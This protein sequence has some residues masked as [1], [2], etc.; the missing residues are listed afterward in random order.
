MLNKSLSIAVVAMLA[1]CST[2]QPP[3]AP[4][5]VQQ[6]PVVTVPVAPAP[7][8][9]PAAALRVADRTQL[10][11]LEL[12]TMWTFENPPLTYWQQQY[13]FTPTTQWLDHARLSSVRF[14]DFC[15]ASFVSSNGLVITNHH[16]GRECVE[17][18]SQ[19]GTDYV[20][21]GFYAATRAE[22]KVCPGLYLDQLVE[23]QNVTARVQAASQGANAN[24]IAKAQAAAIDSIQKECATQSKMQCQVVTLFHG[25]QYQLYKY[26]RYSPVKLVFAPELQAGFF[27]GDPDNFTYPRYDLDFSV[28]RA[29]DADGKTPAQ[30]PQYLQ[31]STTPPNDGDL[32]FVTGNPGSTSRQIPVSEVLYEREYHHPFVIQFLTIQKDLLEQIA[33][34]GPEAEQQVRQNL[35]E[36]ENSLKAY[37]GQYT[38]LQDTML[39]GQKIRWER[40]L[41][42]RVN[43]DANLRA[44][45]GDVWDR[46]ADIQLAKM[47]V[48]PRLNLANAEWLGA[49]HLL[50]AYDLARY[51][52]YRNTP[53]AQ[54][55]EDLR[56]DNW[57]QIESMMQNAGSPNP[58]ISQALLE[59]HLQMVARWLPA[60][61]SLR[62]HFLMPNET[63]EAAAQRIIQNSH[64]MEAAFRSQLIAGG[65]AALASSQDP[66][67]QLGLAM[68][69]NTTALQVR[70]DSLTAAEG[71]QQERLAK[72][73]FATFGTNLPP[74][75][76][77]TLRISDGVVKGYPYNGTEAAPFTTFYGVFGRSVEFRNQMPFTLPAAY[78]AHKN[79]VDLATTLDFV[80]T[81]DITGG[82]SGSPVIDRD[83]RIVGLAFDGNIES[84]PNEFLYRNDTARSVSVSTAA[85]T[86]ALRHIYR[87]D[88]LLRELTGATK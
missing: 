22:E 17:A 69:N 59:A 28:V 36:V 26:K 71:V 72:A 85:I 57:S 1:A 18:N 27:G 68:L 67:V 65:E 79:D 39:L 19:D 25:G 80:S 73:L 45:Y 20:V 75:A 41:R 78:A 7:L 82:N 54:R 52:R 50:Y 8:Q 70:R 32:L 6:V 43:A 42:N 14:G 60:G 66:A 74:D 40:E 49:P 62:G 55:P 9:P 33:A 11:G 13:K 81:N 64:I 77:F 29:Y 35:F 15:S 61:D 87:A 46:M 4:A 47:Q 37:Q 23:V 10:S 83:G 21:K 12:G 5:P 53:E 3:A 63:P 51:V 48:S 38:G 2:A 16:C 58:A 88:A 84:L 31:W 34:Q 86:E 76:T 30:T 24:E 56:G 44:Q